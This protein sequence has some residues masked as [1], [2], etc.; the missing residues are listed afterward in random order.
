MIPKPLIVI[1]LYNEYLHKHIIVVT[2][3][4]I[5][6]KSNKG[7]VKFFLITKNKKKIRKNMQ[8]LFTVTTVRFIR[9]FIIIGQ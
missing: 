2:R 6:L 8:I 7:C 4:I 5:F 3:F 1:Y 9:G